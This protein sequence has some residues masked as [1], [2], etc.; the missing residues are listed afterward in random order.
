MPQR[1]ACHNRAPVGTRQTPVMSQTV[2]ASAN[3]LYKLPT[4]DARTALTQVLAHEPDLVGLQEWYVSRLPLLRRFGDVRVVPTLG[5]R[6]L[7][8]PRDPAYHWVSAVVGGNVVGARAD[9]FDPISHRVVF[10]SRIGRSDR[11]DRLLR[12]EPPRE[13]TVGVY[14]DR[15]LDRTVAL[16]SYHLAP[17]VEKGGSYRPDRPLLRARHESEVRRLERLVA[18]LRRAGHVVYAVG[19]SNFG[20]LR[21]SGLTSAWEGREHRPGTIGTGARKLDDV[22]GPGPASRVTLL[23]TPSDHKAVVAVRPD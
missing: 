8:Q 10:V 2:V 18:E 20:G 21:L 1:A 22:Q 9:R 11:P 5:T 13:V 17:G 19:D 6:L 7:G 23:T 15:L 12:T 4:A 14:G 16:I 3:I